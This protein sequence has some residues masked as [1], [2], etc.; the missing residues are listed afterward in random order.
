MRRTTI[1]TAVFTAIC[2]F[3]LNDPSFAVECEDGLFQS[4]LSET[5]LTPYEG[6][7]ADAFNQPMSFTMRQVSIRAETTW[8]AAEGVITKDTP[9][10]FRD[11]LDKNIVYKENRIEFHS[12][13]GN[14][15]AAMEMGRIIRER[16]NPTTLGQSITLE[17]PEF[18]M[19]VVRFPDPVCFSACAYAFLGGEKRYISEGGQLGVHRFGSKSY[20]FTGD[21]AQSVT[22]DVARYIE[23]MGADQRLLQIASRTAFEDDIFILSES[24]ADELQVTFDPNDR[25]SRFE[26][27]LLNSNV[28][29][30]TTIFHQGFQYAARLHCMDGFPRLVVWGPKEIF[31]VIF[32]EMSNAVAQFST[33]P[34]KFVARV[35]GGTLRNGNAYATFSG[36]DLTTALVR[37]G[38]IRL[39]M[40]WPRDWEEREFFERIKWT[41]MA[42]WF[43]FS[44]KAENAKNTVPIVLRECR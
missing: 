11:F 3:S 31:P 28:V 16:G 37:D 29:A 13:G 39:E 10:V 33:G 18:S 25:S 38:D 34:N 26:V 27:S 40:V 42:T 44:L 24:V 19:D 5:C 41:D 14:L 30:N 36:F 15:Y 21:E 43:N 20:Q 17:N 8:I 23:E 4:T 7:D 35:D 22:S 6:E 9:N 2:V 1:A 32:H 12:P